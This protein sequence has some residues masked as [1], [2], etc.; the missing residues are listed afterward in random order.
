MCRWKKLFRK[1][2]RLKIIL[3]AICIHRRPLITADGRSL[4]EDPGTDMF[5]IMAQLD[6]DCGD[7]DPDRGQS[8]FFCIIKA[9]LQKVWN[10][11]AE[12]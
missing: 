4:D 1:I 8:L 10:P 5:R 7:R 11:A 9:P 6:H 3:P 12:Q 2:L